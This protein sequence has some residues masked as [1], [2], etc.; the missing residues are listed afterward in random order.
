M[1]EYYQQSFQI[2]QA[3]P[4]QFEQARFVSAGAPVVAYASQGFANAGQLQQQSFSVD[5]SSS[6]GASSFSTGNAAAFS[7][8]AGAA[9]SSGAAGASYS[10]GSA[11]ALGASAAGAQYVSEIEQAIIRAQDP[12]EIRETE[13]I[14]I[15]GQRG[16]W[17]NRTEVIN[18]RGVIPITEYLINEDSNPEVINKASSQQLEYVQELAIR[19]LRP[20]TP[21]APGDIEIIAEANVLTPPAPPLIIRQQPARPETPEPQVIREAPPQPPKPVGAKRIVIPGRRLPPPPR[22]LIIERLAALPAKPQ[23]VL[24]ERWLAFKQLKRRVI[25][26]AAGADPVAVKPRN[27]IVQWESPKARIRQ[28]VKYLGE[29]RANPAEYVARYGVSLVLAAKLPEWVRAINTPENLKLGAEANYSDVYMLEGDVQALKLVDLDREGLAEYRSQVVSFSGAGSSSVMASSGFAASSASSSSGSAS[30]VIDELF[31]GVRGG[32]LSRADAQNL[33]LAGSS[34]LGRQ[35]NEQELNALFS[36]LDVNGDGR[37]DPQE[38]R[39]LL[40]TRF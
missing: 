27:V 39:R 30:L 17:A 10:S 15:Q 31:S 1:S 32:R 20:P 37:I 38:F 14:N 34:R 8:G 26:R 33:F 22:K 35:A 24:I 25:Y 16:L 5:S 29:I 13:E 9:F 3:Q 23:S 19:Y 40:L 2:Q 4:V 11:A 7:S 18:W 12:L 21:P 6:F 36:Q 28:E